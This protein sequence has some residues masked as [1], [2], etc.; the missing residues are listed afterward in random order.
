ML[1]AMSTHLTEQRFDQ[2]NLPDVLL[3]GLKDAGFEYCTPIQ[4]E[5]LP[6]ALQGHDIAGRLK[7]VPEKPWP[8]WWRF[9]T[10]Y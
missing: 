9:T 6:V 7:P 8:S 1:A 4:A 5:T 10:S 3:Q 2:Y